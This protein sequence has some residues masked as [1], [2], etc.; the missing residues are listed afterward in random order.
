MAPNKMQLQAM[1]LYP[2]LWM[3]ISEYCAANIL[4]WVSGEW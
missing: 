4:N 3:V 2:S 1:I